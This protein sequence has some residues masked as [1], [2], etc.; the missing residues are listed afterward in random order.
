MIMS[1]VS[2]SGTQFLGGDSALLYSISTTNTTSF[3]LTCGQEIVSASAVDSFLATGESKYQ[4]GLGLQNGDLIL[5][6]SER[7]FSFGGP[8]AYSESLLYDAAGAGSP[9]GGCGGESFGEQGTITNVTEG[10]ETETI[11]AVDPYCSAFVVSTGMLGSG[12]QYQSSGGVQAGD[13]ELPDMTAFQF[14]GTGSGFSSLSV[15]SMSITPGYH[16]LFSEHVIAGGK[17]FSLSGKFQFTSFA[18]TFDSPTA[19]G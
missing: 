15:G 3:P 4:S 6:Q 17:P 16:N 5:L 8:S 7:G 2:A 13:I 18:L 11:P 10:N 19:G 14:S 12:L 9:E 1:Q